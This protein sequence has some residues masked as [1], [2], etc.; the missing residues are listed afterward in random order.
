MTQ[1][2]TSNASD[3]K[4]ALPPAG[5]APASSIPPSEEGR[6]GPESDQRLPEN[7]EQA[8]TASE[9][10]ANKGADDDASNAA[11]P[12]TTPPEQKSAPLF[13]V[14]MVN[15]AGKYYEPGMQLEE[16]QIAK[17]ETAIPVLLAAGAIR[18]G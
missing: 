7:L 3:S 18:E 16:S 13:A 8:A 5:D 2:K 6:P 4:A 12:T 15:L 14:E 10:P 9:Q 11:P 17:D 1:K